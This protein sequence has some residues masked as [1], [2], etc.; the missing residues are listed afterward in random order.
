MKND[1]YLK[2]THRHFQQLFNALCDTVTQQQWPL[3]QQA[4][5]EFCAQLDGHFVD[6][7]QVLY[8]QYE[9]ASGRRQGPTEVMRYEH[10]Q[11]RDLMEAMYQAISGQQGQQFGYLAASLQQLLHQHHTKEESI[12]PPYC[13]PEV[14][15]RMAQMSDGGPQGY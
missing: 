10:D 3:A 5:H 1:A 15:A 14:V 4:C 13:L 8:P 11:M 9:Q 7:E 6:E 12:L 2:R